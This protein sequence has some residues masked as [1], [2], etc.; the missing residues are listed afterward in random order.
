MAQSAT[1]PPSNPPSAIILSLARARRASEAASRV[2]SPLDAPEVPLVV[3][4]VGLSEDQ[5]RRAL[6]GWPGGQR[7]R[8]ATPPGK[9]S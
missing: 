6:A 3:E 8:L 9:A 1:L 4:F 5:Q 7:F 2:V